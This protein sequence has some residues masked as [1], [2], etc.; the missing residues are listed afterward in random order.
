MRLLCGE[1]WEIANGGDD[2]IDPIRPGLIIL[3]RVAVQAGV[4]DQTIFT[5]Q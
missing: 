4:F 2:F 3:R 5:T 1:A